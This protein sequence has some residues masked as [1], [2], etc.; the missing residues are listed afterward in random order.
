MT[1]FNKLAFA[2]GL[3]VFG[4]AFAQDMTPDEMTGQ[5]F[6]FRPAPDLFRRLEFYRQPNLNAVTFFPPS[7]KS[8]KVI[9][10]SRGW[11]KLN[12][13][14][15]FNVGEEAYIP[16]GYFKRNIYTAKVYSDYAFNRASFFSDDPDSIKE[17]AKTAEAAAPAPN[18]GK[19]AA[20][21]FF[22]HKKKCCGLDGSKGTGDP[23][24]KTPTPQ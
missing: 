23:Y 9:D 12:F 5:I 3:I 22:R 7:K 2:L 18:S 24:K 4:I 19:S 6:W 11:I 16:I 17:R 1:Y 20:S 13:I 8:F 10:V 15:S 21:K 14:N